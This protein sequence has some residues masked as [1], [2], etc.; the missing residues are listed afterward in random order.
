MLPQIARMRG[1][2]SK[3]INE[4]MLIYRSRMRKLRSRRDSHG[5]QIYNEV[6]WEYLNLPEK[7]E[8][9]RKQRAKQFWL[10][11]GDKNTNFFHKHA[12]TR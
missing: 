3:E 7:K 4:K 9:F 12:S 5:I 2:A 8:I 11:E 10:S 1:G 6:R